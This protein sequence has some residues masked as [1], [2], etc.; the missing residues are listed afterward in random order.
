MSDEMD[1]GGQS[2]DFGPVVRCRVIEEVWVDRRDEAR[3]GRPHA[4][5]RAE[6]HKRHFV[7]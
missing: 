3:D 6:P 7:E 2:G 5:L 4:T 1:G